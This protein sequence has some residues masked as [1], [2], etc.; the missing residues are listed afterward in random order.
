MV[1]SNGVVWLGK[2]VTE[3]FHA[4]AQVTTTIVDTLMAHPVET[5]MGALGLTGLAA[6]LWPKHGESK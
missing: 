1:K 3:A 2:P 5:V 4:Q 6:V